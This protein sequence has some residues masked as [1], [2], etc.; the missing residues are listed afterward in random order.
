M[1]GIYG[2][3]KNNL[4]THQAIKNEKDFNEIFIDDCCSI[5][6]IERK[7]TNSTIE[8]DNFLIFVSGNCYNLHDVAKDYDV[9]FSSFEDF[10]YT[11]IKQNILEDV[12]NKLDG[13]F[14][15]CI[16]DK[17]NKKIKLI[18]DRFGCKFIYYYF[19]DGEFAFAPT[20]KALL[21]TKA[22]LTIE[23]IAFECFLELGYLLEDY[24]WFKNIKLIKP[25]SILEY[26]IETQSLFQK[27]YWSYSEIQQQDI[28]FDNAVE[29]LGE[30]F[31]KAIKK[32]YNP[33]EQIC[34]PL[35][36]GLDSRMIAAAFNELKQTPNLNF[37]T[38]GQKNCSDFKI[39]N[40]IA[41]KMK[42]K[43]KLFVLDN[44]DI[45]V[46]RKNLVWEVDGLFSIQ[47]M[48]GLNK[49]KEYP[50][51]IETIFSGG[52]GG[53]VYGCTY[54]PTEENWNKIPKEEFYLNIYKNQTKN[55]NLDMKY[56]NIPHYHPH[57]ITNALRKFTLASQQ[58]VMSFFNLY[59]PFLD[60][61]M[62][63]FLFS[64][65]ESYRKDYNLYLN[66]LRKAFPDFYNK[67]PLQKTI[68]KKNETKF[69]IRQQKI[70]KIIKKILKIREQNYFFN[71][72]IYVR[73]EN[74]QKEIIKILDKPNSFFK[75]N[76][77]SFIQEYKEQNFNKIRYNTEEVLKLV[78]AKL[79]F[80]F[81]AEKLEQEKL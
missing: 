59:L 52:I 58:Y 45:I 11:S 63:E 70:K 53:E 34:V 65:K 46:D 54:H 62:I 78:T 6:T 32:R 9:N 38:F 80:D 48:H 31:K 69:Q 19:K 76:N 81:V 51:H 39:S 74:V 25:A 41:K 75:E 55:I 40:M 2:Q 57:I 35:S 18:S 37:V 8:N 67:I 16:Y 10:I 14:Q 4:F 64:I 73:N 50:K 27:H 49:L 79:Y 47:H 13:I 23:P 68:D 17:V 60:N 12:L 20:V 71:Y 43:Q 15:I 26:D 66:A 3:T 22:D 24:T 7:K 44:E 72:P 29:N 21:S 33:N 28:S 42:Q 1:Q 30:L 77:L 56:Y 5:S 61:E 36:G